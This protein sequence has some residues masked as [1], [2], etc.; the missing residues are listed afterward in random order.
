MKALKRFLLTAA[1]LF[2]LGAG[3]AVLSGAVAAVPAG[4]AP[5][6]CTTSWL[7]VVAHQDDDE[8]FLNPSVGIQIGYAVGSSSD[9]M[10]TIYLTT[11]DAGKDSANWGW[12]TYGWDR[13]LGTLN[14]YAYMAGVIST[15]KGSGI[16]S[17]WTESNDTISGDTYSPDSSH[18]IVTYTLNAYS[19]ISVQ[20]MQ[21]PDGNPQGYGYAS[22]NWSS[23]SYN[24]SGSG[25]NRNP[26]PCSYGDS[27]QQFNSLYMTL[28]NGWNIPAMS[29]TSST[30]N[31][32]YSVYD[33]DGLLWTL[34]QLES[35][36]Q[37]STTMSIE[38]QDDTLSG[39]N[40]NSLCAT[41]GGSIPQQEH[42]D[43]IETGV[44]VAAVH[45]YFYGGGTPYY[46]ESYPATSDCYLSTHSTSCTNSISSFNSTQW[47]GF[48]D[49]YMPND[50]NI[51]SASSSACTYGTG[52]YCENDE[53]SAGTSYYH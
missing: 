32:N 40:A 26:G 8:L 14:S 39:S 10:R 44:A 18:T 7:N 5:S 50:S 22:A 36:W 31:T 45:A 33:A 43:H 3:G 38:T 34:G 23:G 25:V 13:E 6:G 12:G 35:Q 28:V 20:F 19:N 53:V 47:T 21:M 15:N 27:S 42:C 49:F 46:F 30:D 16:T 17:Y 11:G 48:V 29:Q 24:C 9:C 51:S 52:P 2:G 4:A 41:S 37:G 1:M